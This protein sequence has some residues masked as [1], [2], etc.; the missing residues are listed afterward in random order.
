PPSLHPRAARAEPG[1]Q[2]RLPQVGRLDHV[3]VDA[4][5]LGELGHTRIVYKTV[6]RPRPRRATMRPA[7][8]RSRGRPAARRC[9]SPPPAPAPAAGAGRPRGTGPGTGACRRPGATPAPTG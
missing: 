8:R 6:R 2:P 5:D 1:R 9:A 7:Q 4:D 3:V